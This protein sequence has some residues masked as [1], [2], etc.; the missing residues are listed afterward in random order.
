LGL[1][2]LK[3]LVSEDHP[4]FERLGIWTTISE[5]LPLRSVKSCHNLAKRLFNPLNYKGHWTSTEEER[6]ITFPFFKICEKFLNYII[7]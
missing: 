3:K 2:G 7:F 6:L 5:A 4:I 1:D